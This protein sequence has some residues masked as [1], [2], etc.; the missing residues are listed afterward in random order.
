ML[1][2]RIAFHAG[3][4]GYV[5]AMQYANAVSTTQPQFFSLGSPAASDDDIIATAIDSDA[6]AG[7]IESYAYTIDAR[8]GR[9]LI[10]TPSGNPGNSYVIEVRGWDYLYQ[11]MLER[12][13]GASGATSV[14]YGKKAFKY[15]KETKVITAASNAITSKLGTGNKLGLPYRGDVVWAKEN[16]VMVPVFNRNVW[17]WGGLSAAEVS[18][19]P[20][21]FWFNAEFPGYVKTLKAFNNNPVGSTNDPAVT[22]KLGGTAITGL[23]V[24]VDVSAAGNETTD[25]PT[26]AGYNANNRFIKDDNIEI[27][28]TDADTASGVRVGLE[29]TPTQ[30]V[31]PDTTDPGTATTGDPRGTYEPLTPPDGSEHIVG[32]LGDNAVNTSNNGGLH[33]IQHYFA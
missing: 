8:Y 20:S 11:P 19:G 17:V 21:G 12:F 14:L 6:T 4:N 13:T 18:G 3:I 27:V 7:T 15:I 33:G 9:N 26:T 22:V 23:T 28:L 25:T 5:P 29:L 24:T 32:L 2:D 10:L 30:F 31:H 1:R 16:G